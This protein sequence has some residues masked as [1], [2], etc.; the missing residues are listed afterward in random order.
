MVQEG[1]QRLPI[2]VRAMSVGQT[3]FRVQMTPS[4]GFA[5]RRAR[6]MVVT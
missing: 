5:V 2:H 1:D 4:V 6:Q 3:K